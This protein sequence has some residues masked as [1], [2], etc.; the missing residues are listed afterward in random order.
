MADTVILVDFGSTYTKAVALDLAGERIIAR[1]QAHSTVGSDVRIGLQQALAGLDAAAGRRLEGAAT[2]A[3]SSA[4]GGLRMAVVGLTPNLSLQAG[5]Q[6]ALG[7]GAKV[8]GVFAHKL[9]RSELAQI[10]QLAPDIVLLVGGT[11]GGNAE[12]IL[13]NAKLLGASGLRA[14][15]VVAG[16]KSCADEVEDLLRQGEREVRVVRNV[17]RALDQLDVDAA[18]DAI[19]EVFMERIAHAKGLDKAAEQL[20][21]V[22]MPTPMAVLR[23]AELLG[24]GCDG[25]PGLGELVVVDIGGATTDIHSIAHGQPR[26]RGVVRRGLPEPFAKRT[27]EGDLGLR[28]NAGSILQAVGAQALAQDLDAGLALTAQAVAERVAQLVDRP[29]SVP[30]D[31]AGRALD[32][33]LAR[34]ATRLALQRHAGTL[35]EVYTDSGEGFIQVGKDLS[36]VQWVLGTG[37]IFQHA[38][39]PA[40]I[41]AGALAC[42]EEPASLRPR[43]PRF[44]V[45]SAY[46]LYAVGLLAAH[47]P[48]AALR[49]AKREMRE[50]LAQA[51]VRPASA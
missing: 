30:G 10:E 3:C 18:R 42:S 29:E 47:A 2:F 12:V 50:V 26:Q 40:R 24:A 9:N 7:A 35:Q 49:L 32:L 15:V 22:I 48:E 23:G 8:E 21:Q 4:A 36:D 46:I 11:D 44:L 39:D 25:E 34:A 19:R 27:V 37:G 33:A 5:R 14:P 17:L 13:H 1:A 41:L 20:G 43:S 6:A 45:D 16:N 31:E 28:W 38:H 51:T